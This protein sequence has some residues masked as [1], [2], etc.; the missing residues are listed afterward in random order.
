MNNGTTGIMKTKYYRI[1]KTPLILLLLLFIS[2]TSFAQKSSHNK[3][4]SS[5]NGHKYNNYRASNST[6]S[7]ASDF[8][9]RNEFS[10]NNYRK[11]NQ[12]NQKRDSYERR[13]DTYPKN[14]RNRNEQ[15]TDNKNHRNR[16]NQNSENY[17]HIDKSGNTLWD[18]KH[19]DISE[20]PLKVYVQ[21]TSSR[22]YK[23]SFKDYVSYA[24]DVW[25]KADNRIN[26]AFTNNSR[27]ADIK[28]IFVENLGKKY[29]ENYLGLTEYEIDRNNEIESTKI[30]ISLLKFGSKVVTDGEVKATIIHEL[31]HA[32]G[33][34]HSDNEKDIMYP[35]IDSKH[36]REK[37][38]NEL[39]T[40][41]KEAVQDA[42]DLGKNEQY[43]W[44]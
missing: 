23:S 22:Y 1:S 6:L 13:K 31:G 35:Y 2:F 4:E 17:F 5:G 32:F 10:Q 33:L 19:W 20:F 24:F 44:K 36:S 18:G 37:T 8:S 3:P 28:I 39:S 43:V 29:D 40:G 9:R 7:E 27:N 42:I 15:Y 34:G 26:Y 14:R 11:Q 38:Y 41:D 21:E 25:E 16:E 30:Q 12:Y